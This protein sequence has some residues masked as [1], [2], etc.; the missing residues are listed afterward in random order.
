[1]SMLCKLKKKEKEMAAH[2]QVHTKKVL[3]CKNRDGGRGSSVQYSTSQAEIGD[4]GRRCNPFRL[5]PW[6]LQ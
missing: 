4:D 1:L 3:Y 6:F 5:H 2:Q